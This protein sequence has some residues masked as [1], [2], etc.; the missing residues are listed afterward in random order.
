MAFPTLQ[1]VIEALSAF[2]RPQV[3]RLQRN[4]DD[5][6]HA[7]LKT[8]HDRQQPTVIVTGNGKSG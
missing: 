8:L 4:V 7:L 2:T 5:L 3:S 1:L 6:Q